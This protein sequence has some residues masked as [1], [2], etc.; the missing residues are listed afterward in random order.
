MDNRESREK[1]KKIYE[2]QLTAALKEY[3]DFA[4]SLQNNSNS[5][6]AQ[7]IRPAAQRPPNPP[8]P[9]SK[10]SPSRP[11]SRTENPPSRDASQDVRRPA[12]TENKSIDKKILDK[13]K[14]AYDA[15][16][17]NYPS[18]G[19]TDAQRI[20][21][22]R[23]CQADFGRIIGQARFDSLKRGANI[24]Q[25]VERSKTEFTRLM[26][27]NVNDVLEGQPPSPSQRRS[28]A[29]SDPSQSGSRMADIGAGIEV[30]GGG[31]VKL[32]EAISMAFR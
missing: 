2:E 20:D 26:H 3:K 12:P 32:F 4:K 17:A 8:Q 6:Q 23:R 7:P 25:I 5:R 15:L 11:V 14:P 27:K 24:N 13:C 28:S 10:S 29:G 19:L 1:I 18:W 31:A 21:W 9:E 16:H 22:G 30:V